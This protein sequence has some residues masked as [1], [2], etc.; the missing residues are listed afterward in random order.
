MRFLGVKNS[1][2]LDGNEL[3]PSTIRI[4]RCRN[5]LFFSFFQCFSSECVLRLRRHLICSCKKR[6][7]SYT[8]S[9]QYGACHRV[10]EFVCTSVPFQLLRMLHRSVSV[11]RRSSSLTTGAFSCPGTHCCSTRTCRRR[12][13]TTVDKPQVEH[14]F[15][16]PSEEQHTQIAQRTRQT[17]AFDF[18][19]DGV[20]ARLRGCI[21]TGFEVGGSTVAHQKHQNYGLDWNGGTRKASNSV[22]CVLA[23]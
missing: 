7:S 4:G 16:L 21:C 17:N 12:R 20:V 5:V 3:C 11:R 8:T 1:E 9:V 22:R 6:C 13:S 10:D 2:L 19:H 23:R 18:G 15:S 14:K